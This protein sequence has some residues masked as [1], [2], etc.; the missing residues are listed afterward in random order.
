MKRSNEGNK[1]LR[2]RSSTRPRSPR[3]RRRSSSGARTTSPGTAWAGAY[4]S[5]GD[6]DKAADA[7]AAT[8]SSSRPSSRC[9]R[10]GTASRS[11]RRR[12]SSAREDQA[13]KREQEARG[14]RAAISSS[15]N[16]E[17]PQQHL[18]EA[19][20]LNTDLWRAHYYLG[21][22]YRDAGQA[23][24]GRRGVHQGARRRTRASRGRTS[25]SASSIASGTTPTRRSRSRSRARRTCPG[26]ER[27]VGHL[28]RA[29]HGLRRQAQRRQ[30]D[31]G[32]HQG[33]RDQARTTTRRSSSAVRRTSARA[34]MTN[35]KRDLEEFSKSGG[36]S[37]EFAKQQAQQDADGHRGRRAPMQNARRRAEAVA[38]GPGQGRQEAPRASKK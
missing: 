25:R 5:S 37:L 16:F 22:I 26:A 35:A 10:C 23:E 7:F 21:R 32:V 27:G 29:R 2:R 20:K 15:V 13:R 33:D 6:W 11:T 12:S 28:V 8:R 31:R 17:K 36:A 34:T 38:R 19:I 9:T 3:T 4:A 18:Q 1:A 30:G 24:G 14:G